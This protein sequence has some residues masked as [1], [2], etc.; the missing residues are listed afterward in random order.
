MPSIDQLEK[1]EKVLGFSID[2]ILQDDAKPKIKEPKL[3]KSI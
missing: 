3:N 1:L 2:D